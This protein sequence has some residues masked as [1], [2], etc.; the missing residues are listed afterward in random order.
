M[1]E[2]TEDGRFV[3]LVNDEGQY[4]LFLEERP[5]PDGWRTVGVAGSRETCLEYVRTKW[6]DMRPLSL[7]RAME[8][9][10]SHT[11]AGT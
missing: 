2:E 5:V 4:S 7:R 10:A 9:D 8:A 1:N 11:G 3:V 6:T